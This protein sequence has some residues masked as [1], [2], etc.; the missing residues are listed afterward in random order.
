MVK[1]I[2]VNYGAVIEITL[3]N[4]DIICG[5]YACFSDG[6]VILNDEFKLEG[7]NGTRTR[8]REYIVNIDEISS[9]KYK[10]I[11]TFASTSTV[12]PKEKF[13]EYGVSEVLT[14]Y[15]VAGY[16]YG[17]GEIIVPLCGH[18]IR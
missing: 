13:K 11:S 16:C 2:P 10:N 7:E 12:V 14:Q 1:R 15:N 17:D 8:E 3:K 18:Y 5:K 9:I 6:F 4:K